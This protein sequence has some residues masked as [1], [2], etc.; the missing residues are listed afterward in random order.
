[1]KKFLLV[2][3]ALIFTLPFFGC[4]KQKLVQ[5]DNGVDYTDEGQG[6]EFDGP[7]EIVFTAD[8]PISE[9]EPDEEADYKLCKEMSCLGWDDIYEDFSDYYRK[10]ILDKLDGSFYFITATNEDC[11]PLPKKWVQFSTRGLESGKYVN[12]CIF[13]SITIN[14]ERF[15]EPMP[16]TEGRIGD[17]CPGG[18]ISLSFKFY[19]INKNSTGS[20]FHLEFG[21]NHEINTKLYNYIN[22]YKNVTCIGTCWYRL[23]NERTKEPPT[24]QWFADF[25]KRNLILLR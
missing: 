9:Y 14:E 20:K 22:I 16:L 10:N 15:S 3:M 2:A 24:Y 11:T 18:T 19:P 8:R 7:Q 23:L 6:I 13:E 4:S 21:E 17:T 25:F 1:M 5:D 12:P